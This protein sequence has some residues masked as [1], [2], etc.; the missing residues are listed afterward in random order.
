LPI[1]NGRGHEHHHALKQFREES[2]KFVHAVDPILIIDDQPDEAEA[3]AELLGTMGYRTEVT[4]SAADAWD[5]LDAG[6]PL[7][8]V[9]LDVRMPGIDGVEFGL[10]LRHS[11]PRLPVLYV[12]GFPI[13]DD[14]LLRGVSVLRKPITR[15]A[16]EREI[17]RALSA[18]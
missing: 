15:E 12:T 9:L 1:A 18:A 3:L 5:L 17:S 16:L 6:K 2:S 7:S 4:R 8:L 13:D 10:A 14:D 11:Y